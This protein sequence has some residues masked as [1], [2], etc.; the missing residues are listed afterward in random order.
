MC[1]VLMIKSL[2]K[3]SRALE[4]SGHSNA[5]SEVRRLLKVAA[6]FDEAII[7]PSGSGKDGKPYSSG[8]GSE[9]SVSNAAIVDNLLKN[10]GNIKEIFKETKTSFIS[11][12]VPDT[13]MMK[14][15]RPFLPSTTFKII[16][17]SELKSRA[18]FKKLLNKAIIASPSSSSSVL[19]GVNLDY[20]KGVFKS[21]PD[22]IPNLYRA[23]EIITSIT[24]A[25]Y[26]EYPNLKS[27]INSIF[28]NLLI[29]PKTIV[30][31]EI[32]KHLFNLKIKFDQAIKFC[33]FIYNLS[34]WLFSLP[35]LASDKCHIIW[36][37]SGDSTGNEG[38]ETGGGWMLHDILH[39]IEMTADGGS[40]SND[41]MNLND[42]LTSKLASS[43]DKY[44]SILR[45]LTPGLEGF[46]YYATLFVLLNYKRGDLLDLI[47]SSEMDDAS[48]LKLVGNIATIS[49]RI[50]SAIG[51]LK[52]KVIFLP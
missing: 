42:D 15:T 36:G 46:D 51:E 38:I 14:G 30:N 52:G 22:F 11:H 19:T 26:D 39:V 1:G 28:D 37:L 4:S 41:L 27:E 40:L 34:E 5:A 25:G 23:A 50:E 20:I 24:E 48:K 6:P 3:L 13:I 33:D 12:V 43:G 35:D 47:Q 9:G 49:E 31:S 32:E 16:N 29:D 7:Y 21:Y 2:I 17:I 18:L 10:L 45:R 44:K 8:D